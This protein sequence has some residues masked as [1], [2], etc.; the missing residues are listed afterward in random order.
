MNKKVV[1]TGI[2]A[3]TSLGLDIDETWANLLKGK[4][5]VKNI[6]LFDASENDTKIAAQ[7]PNNF[8]EYSSKFVKN[9]QDLQDKHDKE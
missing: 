2:N 6:T 4:S 9:R 1:V 7:L 3:I 8:D 5:G